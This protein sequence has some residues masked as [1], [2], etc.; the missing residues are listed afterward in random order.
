MDDQPKKS[1]TPPLPST[2]SDLL[3]LRI[4]KVIR[5]LNDEVETVLKLIYADDSPLDPNDPDSI[6]VAE[7]FKQYIWATRDSEA[8][9][10]SLGADNFTAARILRDYAR[11]VAKNV[12]VAKQNLATLNHTMNVVLRRYQQSRKQRRNM[13]GG[14]S[15]PPDENNG[16]DE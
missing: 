9:E 16:G 6:T 5:T 14:Q 1:L 8:K 10:G 7:N 15:V 11:D 2:I 3:A 12:L 4:G 13:L